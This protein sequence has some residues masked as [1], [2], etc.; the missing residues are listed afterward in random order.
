MNRRRIALKVYYDGRYFDGF[1]RQPHNYT[2]ED[3]LLEVFQEKG[4]INGVKESK[5]Q[6]A[7]RTDK[8]VSA[9]GQVIA[10][11]ISDDKY[12]TIKKYGLMWINTRLLPHIVLWAH[13]EVSK[14]F[15][16]RRH[17]L[18]R[19]YIYIH[20][21]QGENLELVRSACNILSGKHDYCFVAKAYNV[22]TIRDVSI[23]VNKKGDYLIFKIVG[24]SFYRYLIRKILGAILSVGKGELSLEQLQYH[25]RTRRALD[26][27]P[28]EPEGLILWNVNYR[29]VIFNIDLRSLRYLFKIIQ[30]ELLSYAYAYGIKRAFLEHLSSLF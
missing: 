17:A 26:V 15:N 9:L 27:K 8:G 13:S 7:S 24:R 11:D 30:D 21:Y 2:V 3:K 16:P 18:L 5:W 19:E 6:Y 23:T 4:I 29:N 10:F 25:M 1:Q 12:F 28:A 22:P 14:E 20:P